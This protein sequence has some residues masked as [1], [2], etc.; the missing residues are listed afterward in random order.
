M[1]HGRANTALVE[2]RDGAGILGNSG[3]ESL[4][5]VGVLASARRARGWRGVGKSGAVRARRDP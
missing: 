5:G 3:H 1:L 2:R 4:G